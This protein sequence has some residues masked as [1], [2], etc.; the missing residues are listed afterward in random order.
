MKNQ[1][2]H[3]KTRKFS[4]NKLNQRLNDPHNDDSTPYCSVISKLVVVDLTPFN[5]DE[6]QDDHISDDEEKVQI[7]KDS[8]KTTSQN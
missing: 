2:V 5:F 3:S 7:C 1:L 4:P 8:I 6:L